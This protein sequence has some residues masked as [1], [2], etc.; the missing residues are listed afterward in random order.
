MR[1]EASKVPK[2]QLLGRLQFFCQSAEET[3]PK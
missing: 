2:L 3:L 1:L